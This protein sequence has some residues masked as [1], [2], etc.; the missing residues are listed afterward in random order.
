MEFNWDNVNDEY[1]HVEIPENIEDIFQLIINIGINGKQ[2]LWRGQSN[3]KWKIES[4]IQ[5]EIKKGSNKKSTVSEKDVSKF[6]KEIY[7]KTKKWNIDNVDNYNELAIASF[8]Q[9]HGGPTRLVDVTTDPFVALFFACFENKKENGVLFGFDLPLNTLRYTVE[10]KPISMEDDGYNV[11]IYSGGTYDE[12]LSKLKSAEMPAILKSN[13]LE[14][15]IKAQRAMFLFGHCGREKSSHNYI[16]AFNMSLDNKQKHL[17]VIVIDN[18]FKQNIIEIL[19]KSFGISF[20]VLFPDFEGASE[21]FRN[22]K[23]FI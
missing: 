12:I 1:I 18:K 15:R 7:D 3:S 10:Y 5:R 21:Y 20:S 19:N 4:S 17:N 23:D 8:L 6:E 22:R 9:H 14:S 2:I 16:D 13:I 11:T